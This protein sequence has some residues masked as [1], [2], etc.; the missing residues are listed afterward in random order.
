MQET[1]FARLEASRKDLLDLGLRNPLL[2]YKTP[3]GKGIHIVQE[4]S[5]PVFD[6]LVKQGKAMTFLSRPSKEGSPEEIDLPELTEAELNDSYL[7]TRLQTNETDKQ[8]QAKI[9]N[10]YYFAKTSIEEQG[11]NILYLALGM[12]IWYEEGNTESARCAPLILIPVSLERSSA[13]ERFRLRY[14]TSEIGANLSLQAKMMADFSITISNLPDM[15]EIDVEEYFNAI[16]SRIQHRAGWKIERDAIELGF[17]SFGKF[18]IY[19]DLDS[20]KWPEEMKPFD[21]QTII[22]LFSDGFKE[23]EPTANEHLQLDTQTN[24]LDLF[25]VVDADSSQVLAMLAVNEGR[26]LVIQGPPGTGKSQTITNIIAN[27]IGQGKKVLF[28]AEK[29]AALEVVKRRLDSIHLGEACLELHSHKANKKALHEELKRILDLGKPT[30][31]HLQQ[32][33]A[34]LENYR[35]ELNEYCAAINTSIKESGLNPQKVIGHLLH[36]SDLKERIDLPR[37]QIPDIEQWNGENMQRAEAVADKVQATL[38]GVGVPTEMTFWGSQLKVLL[39]H[40]KEYVEKSLAATIEVVKNV[41]NVS[42]A[43]SSHL[44]LNTPTT[45]DE[46]LQLLSSIKLVAA[47]PGLKGIAMNDN[48]WWQNKND[49]LELLQTG[50]ELQQLRNSYK[51]VFIPEAWQQDVLPIRQNLVAYGDKWYKFLISAYGKSVKQ[52]GALCKQPL[53]K[54][55]QGKIEYLNAIVEGKRLETILNELDTL[56]TRLFGYQWQ[57]QR[58]DWD[59][60]SNIADYLKSVHEKIDQ[61][62]QPA[63]LLSYLNKNED[64]S[65]AS[66][67]ADSLSQCMP[68][69]SEA[70]DKIISAIAMDE[71]KRFGGN[72]KK[73]SFEVQLEL[74]LIW[75]QKFPE[76]FQAIQWN[77]MV[78]VVESDYLGFLISP[79]LAWPQAQDYLKISLQKSWY[80]YLIEQAMN[81]IALRKFERS[82]H[83]EAVAKFKQLDLLNLQYNRARAALKHWQNVPRQEAGGQVNILKSEFNRKARYMP[84]RKLVQEAGLAIQAIKP[85]FMMSPMSIANFLPPASIDFDLVIFDEAS[86]VRPVDALGALLRAKQLV[87]VG[88]TRQLPPTS[89]FDKMNT[90]TEDEDNIT[91]DMQSILGMCSGQG[92]NEKMLRWHYRSRHES[93]ISLSNHEFYESK[94]VVFPSP[95][96]KHRMGLVYH[97]LANTV[98]DSGKTRANA[99]EADAVADAVMEHAAKNAKQTLAVVA[100]STAQMQAIQFALEVKRRKNPDLEN[101]FRSHPHEPFVVK[102]LENVQGDE[103]DVIFISIGYGRTEDGKVPQRFGPLNNDGGERRL[104]VLIT[105]AKYRCEV[106]TNMTSDDIIVTTGSKFGIKALKSFLYFAQHG[107]F[108]SLDDTPIPI[109]TPFEDYIAEKL[110]ANGYIIR[111]KVGTQGFYIDIAIVDKEHPGRY[112]LGIDCDGHNYASAKSSR[113]RDR[114]RMQVLEGMGW[115][116][117][118]AWSLDWYY[119]PEK[120]LKR[121]IE[122]IKKAEEITA[123]GDIEMEAYEK[124]VAE[125]I[126]EKTEEVTLLLPM[127]EYASLPS[128]I[129]NQEFHLHPI[130]KIAGWIEDVAKIE[131]P[132]HF[133]EMAYRITR[134]GGISKV[135]ARIK[136]LLQQGCRYLE[137]S[138][139]IKMK[140][141]F[142]WYFTMEN[143][144]IRDRAGITPT[145]K[146]IQ[147]ISPE[148]I[149][150]AIKK[151][152]EESIAVQPEAAFPFIAKLLGFN[153]LTEEIRKELLT[154]VELCLKEE[155]IIKENDLLKARGN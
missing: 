84:I 68:Q 23:Q 107:K 103:R 58:S 64:A 21:N 135:G 117:Y 86:Q 97:H 38:N 63:Q 11:V 80:E 56:G 109:K 54:D 113:D 76:I 10:T 24:A 152:V 143:P 121:L 132:V 145:S 26:N 55:L 30:L 31:I 40:E 45:I 151:V 69:Y 18:M 83:E 133:D 148:E 9:L 19:H 74:L 60:L 102:N 48:A 142:L 108:D 93:L 154:A 44:G 114:L 94:L 57:K 51:D 71:T 144:V 111:K 67:F 146:K 50:K 75:Q 61:R 112:I 34:L 96:S 22:S 98:Y 32:E 41:K 53:P 128:E 106:F 59:L 131:S 62:Q 95:G 28:V 110:E 29:M 122:A 39:P 16:E 155:L 13:Q 119:N 65:I 43:A 8:L 100:F 77:N 91:A 25:Q 141:D 125:L 136:D 20:S 6:I 120:E 123:I 37:I 104:N 12:L 92:V 89:F 153:R 118:R 115:R 85:V 42:I 79:V 82:S 78:E 1:I 17:F 81:S 35:N 147:F 101:F 2:N 5:S 139:K 137:Q 127:Y 99:K 3:K 150:L 46:T 129:G 116:M 90:D 87:V 47:S 27:A 124:E 130:G 149:C 140:G 4:K 7:D 15:E 73:L 72:F 105:R 66:N 70:I 14:T 88:D 49:I 52:L 36:L 33:I 138:G 126:R 134:A